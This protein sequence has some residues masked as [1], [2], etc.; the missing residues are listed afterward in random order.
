MY[1]GKLKKIEFEKESFANM[2]VIKNLELSNDINEED[3]MI[4][5]NKSSGAG[6]QHINKTE[7][8]VRITH[9]PTGIVVECQDERSQTK[10]KEKAIERLKEKI[11]Q[12]NITKLKNNDE[13]QRKAIKNKLF[14]NTPSVIFDFD[15]NS[16]IVTDKKLEYKIKDI[17]GGNIDIIFND[18]NE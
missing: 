5:T 15:L 18:T 9:V 3:L 2:V 7:S 8:A 14:G 6:G 4:Q 1:S 16:V 13:K 11:S 10:N 17:Q 12:N